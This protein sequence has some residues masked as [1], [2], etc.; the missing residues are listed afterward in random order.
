MMTEE[1]IRA[2]LN[3]GEG[4]TVEYKECVNALSSSVFETVASFSNRYG[5]YM[6]LGVKEVENKGVVIGVNRNAIPSLKK[7]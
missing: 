7:Q 1:K 4:F 2:L 5:G 3:E 6:L